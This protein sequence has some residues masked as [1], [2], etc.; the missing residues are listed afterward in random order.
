MARTAPY[1]PGDT[2]RGEYPS[3]W[4]TLSGT[5]PVLECTPAADPNRWT[6]T[7]R[8]GSEERGEAVT[9]TYT[10]NSVGRSVTGSRY[11]APAPGT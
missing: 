3:P 1:A 7:V 5:G 4:G 8:L 11:L 9:M 2:V 10:V 6:V